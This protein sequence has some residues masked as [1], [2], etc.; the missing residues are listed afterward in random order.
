MAH[1]SAKPAGQ[2]AE[3]VGCLSPNAPLGEILRQYG[4]RLDDL[5]AIEQIVEESALAQI[6]VTFAFA[7]CQPLHNKVQ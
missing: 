3:W 1:I 7:F 6:L 5:R 4:V 2:T